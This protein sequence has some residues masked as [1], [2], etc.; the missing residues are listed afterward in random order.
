[1][2]HQESQ[3]QAL[4]KTAS[5]T[6]EFLATLEMRASIAPSAPMT[7]PRI[8]QLTQKTNQFNLTTRRYTEA[9]VENL[10]QE[11]GAWVYGLSVSDRFGDSGLV[12]VAAVKSDSD[13]WRID[14]L[15]LSCRVMGRTVETAFLAFLGQRAQE[16]GAR[17][18]IGEYVPTKKNVPVRD[19]YAQHGFEPEDE[20]GHLWRLDLRAAKL[21]YP[22]YI[23]IKF[24]D[25]L[26]SG[27]PAAR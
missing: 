27:T 7:R 8:A 25:E 3:R 21:S 1:M 26:V 14:T 18:L 20:E 9:E 16:Y 23:P 4:R 19:L 17:Y 11:P 6:E 15:L 24:H 5:T 12:G 10:E 2:Y 22:D 13:R